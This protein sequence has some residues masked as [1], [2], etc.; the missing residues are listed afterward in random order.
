MDEAL[1]SPSTTHLNNDDAVKR[2]Q[3]LNF[4]SDVD[5]LL[6]ECSSPLT[7]SVVLEEFM[8]KPHLDN[9]TEDGNYNGS[10]TPK[11]SKGLT[12]TEIAALSGA[13]SGF[14][15]GVIVCPLD[16]AKTRLQAQGL[17][18]MPAY[19]SGLFGSLNTIVR[20]E[21]FRGLYKGVVP[22]VLGYFPTWMIY[23]TI[24]EK[25]KKKYPHIFPNDFLSHSASALTAG[26]VSTALTNPIWVV[27]TRLMTQSSKSRHSTNYSGTIDA[28]R[29]MYK[30]EG[31]KVF[32]LGL[33]PSLFGLFHV[34]IQFPVYEKLKR[35]LYYN[36]TVG[37]ME[38]GEEND[39][40][41][42]RLIIASCASKIVASTITYP[43][44]ILR[45]RMQIKSTGG[46]QLGVFSLIKKIS[47]KEGFAGFYS[48]FVTN[49]FRTVP[50]SAITLVSFEY[51]KKSFKIWNDTLLL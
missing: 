5:L 11:F 27:K 22:I 51:F 38:G 8:D 23:F 16:V 40:N 34:A 24:Y 6:P 20:D 37:G 29:K 3:D 35:L 15:A 18:E 32:Y 10:K 9:S 44:E 19:Y 50:A 13:L 41:L 14:V 4:Q 26:A 43:H 1:T 36:T 45:T 28:F 49:M 12:D 21:G 25:C 17:Y 2:N 33:V 48:G 39:V 30:T 42:G 47:V 31:L 7:S 46:D